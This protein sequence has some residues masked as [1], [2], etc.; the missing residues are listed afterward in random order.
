VMRFTLAQMGVAPTGTEAP[1]L[2]LF[3]D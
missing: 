1:E 3:A 2:P